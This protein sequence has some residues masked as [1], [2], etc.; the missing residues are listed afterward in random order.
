MPCFIVNTNLPADKI[1]KSFMKDSS[2]LIAKLLGK[3]E[4][5]VCVRVNANQM[6]IFG[7]S[8]APCALVVLDSIGAVG[9]AK[10]QKLVP[11]IMKHVEEA[12][13]IPQDRFYITINDVPG[14][15]MGWNGSTFG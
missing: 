1:P 7:G 14:S 3:P 9:G 11:P 8:D 12:L 2:H 4:S 6:M 13:G 5:Y 10:N 15:N